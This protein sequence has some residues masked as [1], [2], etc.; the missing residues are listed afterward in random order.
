MKGLKFAETL[1]VTF[2][3]MTGNKVISK[4]AYFNS[5]NQVIINKYDIQSSLKLAQEQIINKI[6][7]WISEGSGWIIKKVDNH[8]LN[9]VKYE[10]IK[11]SSYIKLSGHM[12]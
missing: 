1:K 5:I 10:P 12:R 7:V 9:V 11:G 8:Y 4:T 3:K 2:E 6:A